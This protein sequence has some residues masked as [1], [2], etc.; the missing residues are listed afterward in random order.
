MS[1]ERAPLQ[2]TASVASAAMPAAVPVLA[3]SEDEVGHCPSTEERRTMRDPS[4]IDVL[5]TRLANAWRKSPDLR[6]G[7]LLL[8]VTANVAPVLFN[9]E[10]EPLVEAVEPLV[11]RHR[12]ASAK[13]KST[14]S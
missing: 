13:R 2:E 9:V 14:P 8:T 6:L 12:G 1:T 4:R 3:N 11:A 5:L 10:D 7:Q